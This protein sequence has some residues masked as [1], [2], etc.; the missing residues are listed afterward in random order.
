[1]NSKIIFCLFAGLILAAC[2]NSKLKDEYLISF[3]DE[4]TEMSGYKN[5]A[6]DIIIPLGKYDMCISDTFKTYAIVLKDNSKFLAIDRDEKVLYEVFNYDNG[7]D[8]ISEGMFRIK[9]GE[10]IGF[11]DA[12]TGKIVIEPIY[13]CAFPFEEGIAKVT[14]NCKMIQEGEYTSCESEEWV[15][16]DKTGK[17]IS[18]AKI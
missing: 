4:K 17:I 14:E 8:Y 3:T 11:A 2:S 13:M 18:K 12:K 16:I 15:F 5:L 7:P 6:G 10:K 1:M 9:K